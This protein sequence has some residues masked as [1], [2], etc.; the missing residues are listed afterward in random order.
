MYYST[1]LSVILI[2]RT[3]NLTKAVPGNMKKIVVFLCFSLF[4]GF[5]S[6]KRSNACENASSNLHFIKSQT[7]KA[8]EADSISRSHFYAYRALNA[9]EKSKT[10]MTSCGCDYAVNS[11]TTSLEHLKKATRTTSLVETKELLRRAMEQLERSI[12][13]V[14]AHET[15][16]Q[17]YGGDVLALNT[18]LSENLESATESDDLKTLKNTIDKSLQNFEYS[19]NQV[20]ETVNCKEALHLATRIYKNCEKELLK[21]DLTVGKKYYHQR[22]KQIA[23][24]AIK[25]IGD[26]KP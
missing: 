4:I 2:D 26:C 3:Q 24:E 14:T 9:A 22:T 11:F 10:P 12:I 25:K 20:V 13:S 15:H 1:L 23:G 21:D 7:L 17:H 6:F 5:I 18:K 19:M 8:M 16:G